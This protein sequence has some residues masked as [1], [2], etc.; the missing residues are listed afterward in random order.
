MLV[1]VFDPERDIVDVGNRHVHVLEVVDSAAPGDVDEAV[2][3]L[4]GKRMQDDG[5]DDAED[6][7][8]GSDAQRQCE[9]GDNG[10]CGI[11][12]EC[13]KSEADVLKQIVEERCDGALVA[14]GL[15]DERDVAEFATRGSA[16]DFGSA[17]RDS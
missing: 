5:V 13:A 9:Y 12:A 3:V 6:R 11:L 7:G 15:L 14:H 16:E 4:E 8:V 2:G 17:P 1:R 10:E